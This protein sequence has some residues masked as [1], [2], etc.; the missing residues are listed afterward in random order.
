MTYALFKH[1]LFLAMQ[2]IRTVVTQF[3]T[4]VQQQDRHGNHG[5]DKRDKPLL[6]TVGHTEIQ[7]RSVNSIQTRG[8]MPSP[9]SI[10]HGR[11]GC[12]KT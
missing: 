8:D 7:I 6:I 2:N 1:N 10:L 11:A 12:G 3:A 5:N 4:A 9:Y